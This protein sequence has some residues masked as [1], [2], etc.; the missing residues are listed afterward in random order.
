MAKTSLK[1]I[2]RFIDNIEIDNKSV[3][4]SQF[5]KKRSII[6]KLKNKI[7][8]DFDIKFENKKNL[9]YEN[10]L[11]MIFEKINN[12]N[13]IN[14][15]NKHSLLGAIN[16]EISIQEMINLGLKIGKNYLQY[17]VV[18]KIEKEKKLKEKK[19]RFQKKY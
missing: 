13:F 11:K 7:V 12:K 14:C 6:L 16:K 17:K 3:K 4:K 1:E 19:T 15:D 9:K 8:K 18:N 10:I 2:E 5:Y